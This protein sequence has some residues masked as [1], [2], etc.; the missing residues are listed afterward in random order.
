MEKLCT[1]NIYLIWRNY[2]RRNNVHIPKMKKLC[3]EWLYITTNVSNIFLLLARYQMLPSIRPK[4]LT[5]DMSLAI[6]RDI[7]LCVIE[8]YMS[9][10]NTNRKSIDVHY[11]YVIWLF[12]AT[13]VINVHIFPSPNDFSIK[14]FD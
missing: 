13:K 5:I 12:W 7:S 3:W 11:M 2:T 10:L 1:Y 14:H 4:V 6:S 9:D 8:T